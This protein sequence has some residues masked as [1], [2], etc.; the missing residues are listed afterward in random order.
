MAEVRGVRVRVEGVVQGVGYRAWTASTARELGLSGW[1]R[2]RTDGSVEA[3][4]LGPEDAV[5]DML[6]RCRTGP[7]YAEVTAVTTF[8]DAARDC[9]GFSV[10]PTA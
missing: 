8:D 6:A 4:F 2:N 9:V 5:A 10:L 3:V 1:V 7:N